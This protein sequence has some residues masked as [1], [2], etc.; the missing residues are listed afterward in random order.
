LPETLVLEE[1]RA[2]IFLEG[3][4]YSYKVV[5]QAKFNSGDIGFYVYK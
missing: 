1:S 2:I 5:L 4:N 3:P